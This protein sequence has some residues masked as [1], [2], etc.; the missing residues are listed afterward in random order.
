MIFVTKVE[1]GQKTSEGLCIVCAK[2]VGLPIENMMGGA[3]EKLGLTPE[4][5]A[6]MSEEMEQMLEQG[7][8]LGGDTEDAEAADEADEADENH[9]GANAA[10]TR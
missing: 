9:E 8:D 4:Q 3:F 5:L 10:E 2:E 1:N 6:G 7:L